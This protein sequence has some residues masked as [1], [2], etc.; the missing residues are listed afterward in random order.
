MM[1]LFIV[2]GGPVAKRHYGGLRD[3]GQRGAAA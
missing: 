1:L 3:F 2:V